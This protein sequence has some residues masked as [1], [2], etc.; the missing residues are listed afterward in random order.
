[1]DYASPQREAPH[2]PCLCGGSAAEP[3]QER[4]IKIPFALS[5]G[6]R[7]AHI[8]MQNARYPADLIPASTPAAP[9]ACSWDQALTCCGPSSAQATAA[10]RT[11]PAQLHDHV[12]PL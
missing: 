7:R 4:D 2:F 3:L 5:S 1:M 9:C 8:A 12:T 11:G 10:K 6:V